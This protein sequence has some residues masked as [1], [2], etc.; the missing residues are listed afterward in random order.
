MRFFAGEDFP[1]LSI[2]SEELPSPWI[3]PAYL[4]RAHRDRLVRMFGRALLAFDDRLSFVELSW[5]ERDFLT[6]RKVRIPRDAVIWWRVEVPSWDDRAL[7]T[8]EQLREIVEEGSKLHPG[9]AIYDFDGPLDL[10]GFGWLGAFKVQVLHRLIDEIEDRELLEDPR[11]VVESLHEAAGWLESAVDLLDFAEGMLEMRGFGYAEEACRDEAMARVLAARFGGKERGKAD[12]E[13]GVLVKVRAGESRLEGEERAALAAGGLLDRE[14]GRYFPV[15]DALKREGVWQRF[16]KKVAGARGTERALRELLPGWVPEELPLG[17]LISIMRSPEEPRLDV[18]LRGVKASLGEP[19]NRTLRRA[20]DLLSEDKWEEASRL[21]LKAIER[22]ED[23]LWTE[24]ELQQGAGILGGFVIKMITTKGDNLDPN[25]LNRI[26]IASNATAGLFERA[27]S[28]RGALAAL[29][30]AG[31]YWRMAHSKRLASE[32]LERARRLAEDLGEGSWQAAT[33]QELGD[34]AIEENRLEQAREAYQKALTIRVNLGDLKGQAEG[35]KGLGEVA[36]LKEQWEEAKGYYERAL[37]IVGQLGDRQEESQM[38]KRLGQVALQTAE[39]DAAQGY[40]ERALAVAQEISD[41][42]GEAD[43]CNAL[44]GVALAKGNY[45]DA[46]QAY[47]RA[48]RIF[49]EIGDDRGKATTYVAE[50]ILWKVK[51]ETERARAA[52]E[53][54]LIAFDKLGDRLG[55]DTVRRLLEALEPTPKPPNK[56]K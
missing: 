51:G 44:F 52:F 40:L 48:R 35:F 46:E 22:G 8:E 23:R 10:P 34:L 24:K 56:N 7:R 42:R 18:A 1:K 39:H 27:G 6:W 50:G 16:V 43:A 41:R 54:A 45:E 49:R 30:W 33:F 38:N 13:L 5:A 37:S 29:V 21:V 9:R 53:Y 25:R 28:M 11:W 20:K 17:G 31:S 19:E 4:S 3:V 26:A 14:T 2:F 15:M 47:Q 32:A 36:R 55:Q 12:R